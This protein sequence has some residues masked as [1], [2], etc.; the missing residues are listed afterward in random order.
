MTEA[1]NN[2]PS[3]HLVNIAQHP[4]NSK[5]PLCLMEILYHILILDWSSRCVLIEVRET[6]QIKI[7][8][9]SIL[10]SKNLPSSSKN[11]RFVTSSGDFNEQPFVD[12]FLSF[13]QWTTYD[14]RQ[15]R[16]TQ[17]MFLL[18][19]SLAVTFAPPPASWLFLLES[20]NRTRGTIYMIS[21]AVWK[22]SL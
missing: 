20:P 16:L 2:V 17:T 13:L 6:P 7:K 14:S 8:F 10:F 15:F 4:K 18:P 22:N 3:F 19:Y 5:V 11:V 9:R 12:S 1:C 21:T